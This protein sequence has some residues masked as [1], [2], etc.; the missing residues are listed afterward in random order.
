MSVDDLIK[1]P[2]LIKNSKDYDKSNQIR[3]DIYNKIQKLHKKNK[4]IT[5]LNM[6]KP[7]LEKSVR[8]IYNTNQLTNNCCINYN[9]YMRLPQKASE[10]LCLLKLRDENRKLGIVATKNMA[11]ISSIMDELTNNDP[12]E[13]DA[14]MSAIQEINSEN[15]LDNTFDKTNQNKCLVK[16]I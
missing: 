10:L 6:R 11:E 15:D 12:K 14:I 4:F 1:D 13:V 5:A 7:K 2:I 3:K 9:L 16:K 8:R